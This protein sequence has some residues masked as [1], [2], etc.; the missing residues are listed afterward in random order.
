MSNMSRRARTTLVG[1]V[2]LA[3]VLMGAAVAAAS[4]NTAPTLKSPGRDAKVHTGV[5]TFKVYDPGLSGAS[6]PVFVA[7]NRHR[8]INKNGLLNGSCKVNKG[9]DFFTMKHW[10]G[11]PGWW[12]YKSPADTSFHGWYA[13]TPGKYYWQAEHTAPLCDAPGCEIHSAVRAFRVVG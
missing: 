11:H 8:Q 2:T 13:S 7:V 12:I 6:S 4:N 5:I 3:L 9:C 10:K 1:V